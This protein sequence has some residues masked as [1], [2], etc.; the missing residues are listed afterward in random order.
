MLFRSGRS[1][2]RGGEI[3][4]EPVSGREVV[5]LAPDIARRRVRASSSGTAAFEL[6]GRSG[7]HGHGIATVVS[8][9]NGADERG[10]VT[11]NVVAFVFAAAADAAVWRNAG[12]TFV[13]P[14][15]IGLGAGLG[16]NSF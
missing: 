4:R 6:C 3:A 12:C 9:S 15:V 11:R 2:R 16:P 1:C 7:V 14:G 8:T 10:G 5:L 13:S